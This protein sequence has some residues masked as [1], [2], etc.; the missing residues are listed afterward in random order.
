MKQERIPFDI[1]LCAEI[2]A[3]KYRVV[4]RDGK[5]VRIICWD[6]KGTY[7]VV[8]LIQYNKA[9]LVDK[10]TKKGKYDI[11]G[12]KSNFDLF[13]VPNHDYKEVTAGSS[14]ELE[15]KIKEAVYD[16]LF[17][18]GKGNI[19]IIAGSDFITI[20]DIADIARYFYE[21]GLNARKKD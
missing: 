9:E 17:D 13:L 7:P 8:A 14:N 12:G 6:K 16:S 4:T 15:K 21:L 3:G 19:G 2:E 10:Y 18:L 1:K 5:S 20:D 11:I